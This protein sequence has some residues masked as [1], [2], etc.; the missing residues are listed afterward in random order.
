MKNRKKTKPAGNPSPV[1]A[2][3]KSSLLALAISLVLVVIAAFL[4]M[5]QVLPI[6]STKIVNPVIKAVSALIAALI[7][8][9]GFQKRNFLFGGLCGICYMLITTLVF[10][11]LSGEFAFGIPLLTDAGLCPLAGM[12]GGILRSLAK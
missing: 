6:S 9:K 10:A 7:V 3:L 8:V 2:V 11:L 5:K 4:M 12:V 1:R